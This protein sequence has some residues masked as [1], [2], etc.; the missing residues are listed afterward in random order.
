MTNSI[1]IYAILYAIG[2]FTCIWY[3]LSVA[4]KKST[5]T[6]GAKPS[7]FEEKSPNEYTIQEKV[8]DKVIHFILL[9]CMVL[10]FYLITNPDTLKIGEALTIIILILWFILTKLGN[11]LF[12][13]HHH[14]TQLIPAI[15][16]D[17]IKDYIDQTKTFSTF[18]KCIHLDVM[19]GLYVKT[20]SPEITQ[21]LSALKE[22][23][24]IQF[25]IHLMVK[26]PL[27]ELNALR[28]FSNV[29][30]V[31]VHV[32]TIDE[33]FFEESYPFEIGLVFN[34]DT[35]IRNYSSW[36]KFVNVIQIMT[37][38]PGNQG[39]EYHPEALSR[40]QL[41][42]EFGFDGEIHIDGHI[43]EETI[44]QILEFHPDVLN[45]GSSISKS[46][47]PEEVYKKLKQL[48]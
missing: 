21:I 20:K 2:I 24:E 40:V 31:Y 26:Y 4:R 27:K 11:I 32:E 14:K 36:L 25:A 39:N 35:D 16:S 47:N 44:P 6:A 3:A 43:N 46:G 19:D 1:L 9:I 15:L 23:D 29:P 22:Y 7:V 48:C 37:V 5:R 41:L 18:S 12:M 34:P 45:V 13:N 10:G 30:L 38:F 33:D 17:R 28:N 42:R 8:Y